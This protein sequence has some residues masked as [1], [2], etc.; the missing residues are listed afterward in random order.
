MKTS[1][2]VQEL[3]DAYIQSYTIALNETHNPQIAIGAA[4]SVCTVIGQMKKASA[5]QVDPLGLMLASLMNQ[6]PKK[7]NEKSDKQ[8]GDKDGK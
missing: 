4:M 5:G 7:K 1:P 6:P 3:T 2:L 8:E